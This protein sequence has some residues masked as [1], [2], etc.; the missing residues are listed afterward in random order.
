MGFDV[1]LAVEVNDNRSKFGEVVV[2]HT[3][4]MDTR[5]KTNAEFRNE[6]QN[7]VEKETNPFALGE[8]SWNQSTTQF[9]GTRSSGQM[10]VHQTSLKLYFPKFDGEDPNGW[11]FRCE[12]YF[13]FL[14]IEPQQEVQ[15]ASFHLEGMA[16]QWFLAGLRD[17]VRLESFT[18]LVIETT[19][20]VLG[21]PP[22]MVKPNTQLQAPFEKITGQKAR[23]RRAKGL[24]Y[25]C[26]EKFLPGHCCIQPQLFMIDD[27][28]IVLE[29]EWELVRQDQETMPLLEISLYAITGVAQPQ[30]VRVPRK[31]QNHGISVLIDGASTH[32]FIDSS[33]VTRLGLPADFYVLP[34]AA[35]HAVLGVQW[36]VTLG[37][38]E[39]DYKALTIKLTKDG[40]VYQ[41]QG[42][43]PEGLKELSAKGLHLLDGIGFLL[44]ILLVKEGT[45][46]PK[47]PKDLQSLLEEFS[48]VFSTPCGLPPQH[49]HDHGI[50]LLPDKPPVSAQL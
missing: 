17:E 18:R 39:M 25:Y 50:P 20:G 24:Y 46:D 8:S 38:V 23:E 2:D 45:P 32:N 5:G 44:Q 3:S 30:T 19:V 29:E 16:L 37:P 4:S 12:Q 40:T 49:S 7:L 34:V 21:P 13:E 36:L 14:G 26:D 47:H 10:E 41:F 31:L 11:I 35:C 43:K 9:G 6:G 22:S 48:Q 28:E 1:S 27:P 33:I 42:N 15:L